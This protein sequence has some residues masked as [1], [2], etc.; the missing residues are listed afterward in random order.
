MEDM[1]KEGKLRSL[2]VSNFDIEDLKELL[3]MTTVPVAAVQSWFDPFHQD[4][5]TRKFCEEHGI[6]YIGY[7]TLGKCNILHRGRFHK[8][9]NV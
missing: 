6:Q 4:R 2:G 1:T 9:G 3:A 8:G 5:K 7:S